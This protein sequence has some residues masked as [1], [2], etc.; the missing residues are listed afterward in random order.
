MKL[1][2]YLQPANV[3]YILAKYLVTHFATFSVEGFVKQ[4]VLVY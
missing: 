4:L 3:P 1:V 2:Q